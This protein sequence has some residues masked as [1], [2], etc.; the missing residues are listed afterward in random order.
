MQ[1]N[2]YLCTHKKKRLSIL[3]YY[4]KT[5]FYSIR[6]PGFGRTDSKFN[7]GEAAGEYHRH[8]YTHPLVETEGHQT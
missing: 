5:M 7:G 8:A 2:P 3:D 6:L 1:K 4:G